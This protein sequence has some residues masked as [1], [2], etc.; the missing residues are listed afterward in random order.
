MYKRK[1]QK[2]QKGMI[3]WRVSIPLK[4]FYKVCTQSLCFILRR[5]NVSRYKKLSGWKKNELW[6]WWGEALILLLRDVEAHQNWPLR[7]KR[8]PHH[9]QNYICVGSILHTLSLHCCSWSPE[10]DTNKTHVSLPTFFIKTCLPGS[11]CWGFQW[12]STG[13]QE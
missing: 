11:N 8:L 10:R 9:L 1:C 12:I 7:F 2:C 6:M 4:S 13:M 3:L 5:F